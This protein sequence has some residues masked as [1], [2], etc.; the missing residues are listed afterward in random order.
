MKARHCVYKWSILIIWLVSLKLLICQIFFS[1]HRIS[2]NSMSSSSHLDA[3]DDPDSEIDFENLPV[4][5]QMWRIAV[6]TATS[7][8]QLML[9]LIQLNNSLA[10]EKSI[11]KVVRQFYSSDVKI[12]NYFHITKFK[13]I[14][15]WF[16]HSTV[17][18]TFLV[19]R[20]KGSYYWKQYTEV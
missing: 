17:V 19:S 3:Y 7:P 2:L 14:E 12:C 5:L 9:C 10:W 1:R 6:A 15:D 4:G 13:W 18:F 11:M 16:L 8:S 20:L